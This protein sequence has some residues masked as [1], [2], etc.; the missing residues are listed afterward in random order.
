MLQVV[1]ARLSSVLSAVL[2]EGEARWYGKTGIL[3][4]RCKVQGDD[5]SSINRCWSG[6]SARSEC[7]FSFRG[8]LGS[9]GSDLKRMHTHM[10]QLLKWFCT[11]CQRFPGGGGTSIVEPKA[12]WFERSY[13]WVRYPRELG[14]N[15]TGRSNSVH[16]VFSS[17][18]TRVYYRDD[19]RNVRF[20]LFRLYG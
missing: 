20:Q 8:H 1:R 19:S 16:H 3:L 14:R 15:T 13:E 5:E 11:L 7:R 2:S 12:I 6:E 9:L 17:I 10:F 18:D 4:T